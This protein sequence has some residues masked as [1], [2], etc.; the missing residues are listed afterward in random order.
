[1]WQPYILGILNMVNFPYAITTTYNKYQS[2]EKYI[3]RAT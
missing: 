1:M 3:L 2:E